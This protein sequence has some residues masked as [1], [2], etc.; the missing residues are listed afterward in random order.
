MFNRKLKALGY[1]EWDKVNGNNTEHF[2][3]VVIWL[4]DQKIR[5]YTIEK[6]NDLRNIKSDKWPEVFQ[7]YCKDID[8]PVTTNPLD[9]LEWLIGRAVNLEYTDDCKKYQQVTGNKKNKQE[10]LKPSLKS[11]NPLDNLDFY[12]KEFKNGVNA[13]AKLLNI[14]KHSSHLTTLEACSKLVC[15]RLNAAAIANPNT[16]I[17]KGKPFPI[18]DTKS[19]ISLGDVVLDNA[20]KGLTLLYIHDL[21]NLQTKINELIVSVQNITANPKTDTKLGKVGK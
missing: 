21:R 9:Q 19:G 15:N 5:L 11:S 20:A 8:C 2:R 13:I 7:K 17:V 18:M 10:S 6:R 16:V 12:S 1:L 3:K 4:E 14:P